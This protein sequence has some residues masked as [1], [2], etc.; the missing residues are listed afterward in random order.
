MSRSAPAKQCAILLDE[1]FSLLS[2]QDIRPERFARSH[3]CGLTLPLSTLA[4]APPA[5]P[6][7]EV[8]SYH[9]AID[10]VKYVFGVAPSVAHLRPGNILDANSL[11]CFG[12]ALQK[13]G[14][15]FVLVKG[16]NPLTG[17]FY[18]EGAA[19]GDTL[20]VHILDLQ[21]DGKQGVGTFSPGF[22]AINS[23][24]YTPMLE[25][26]RCRSESRSIPST[27]RKRPPPF[28]RS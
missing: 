1:S 5:T 7:T 13:P 23:T 16:D 3:E 2:G 8:V 18:I 9:A 6:K 4:Q 26:N 15:T 27:T 21:V 12:N 19:P 24:H 10:N 20:V 14:D 11:D 25:R 22:G 17:P 28:R